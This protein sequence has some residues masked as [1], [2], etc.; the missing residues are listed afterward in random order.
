MGCMYMYMHMCMHANSCMYM[1][2]DVLITTKAILEVISI[3]IA[4]MK[5]YLLYLYYN[6]KSDLVK[7]PDPQ[8]K[9]TS[10]TM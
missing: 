7:K 10:G 8:D 3:S 9:Y 6:H 4:V 1:W 2:K 5:R